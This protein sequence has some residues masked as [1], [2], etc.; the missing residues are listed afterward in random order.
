[1]QRGGGK[2]SFDSNRLQ[3]VTEGVKAGVQ[4]VLEAEHGEVL[5]AS[6]IAGLYSGSLA[7]FFIQ[8][9]LSQGR[10]LPTVDWAILDQ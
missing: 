6:S 7:H 8:N 4:K 5:L 9:Q 1:M 10:A 3:S 2:G